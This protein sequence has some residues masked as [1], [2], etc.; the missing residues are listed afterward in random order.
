VTLETWSRWREQVEREGMRFAAAPE[1]EVFPTRDKPLKPYV[2]AVRASESTR[3]VI[4]ECD[5]EVVVADII[6]SAASLAAQAEE[7]RWATLV[8]H[9][10]PTGAP[11]TGCFSSTG[12]GP[13]RP[14][15]IPRLR[16]VKL[17]KLDRE[18]SADCLARL[19]TRARGR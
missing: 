19:A 13:R 9:V 12:S 3:E 16:C 8:P 14:P 17:R 7:R 5:P 4:R 18:G 6:T 2:A 10:L 15:E 11:G 1:Y